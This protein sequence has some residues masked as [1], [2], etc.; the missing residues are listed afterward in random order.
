VHVHG[1]ADACEEASRAC[2]CRGNWWV[3]CVWREGAFFATVGPRTRMRA[4]A[5]IP[6]LQFLD[7]LRRGTS[8]NYAD[9]QPNTVPEVSSCAPASQ[10]GAAQVPCH[11]PTSDE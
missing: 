10:A 11:L 2:E 4:L 9:L 7:N 1:W 6:P 5:C 3:A 8:I